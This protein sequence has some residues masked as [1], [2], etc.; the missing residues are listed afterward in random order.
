MP[1]GGIRLESA[2]LRTSPEPGTFYLGQGERLTFDVAEASD[3]AT[4]GFALTGVTRDPTLNPVAERPA[5]PMN[6][7]RRAWAWV[8]CPALL[9]NYF[10][11]GALLLAEP[12]AAH[13][14]FFRLAPSWALYPLVA[15]STVATVIASQALISGVYSLT[16][17]A[18][19]LGLLPRINV[20]HTSDQQSG[21]VYVPVINWLLMLVTIGLVLKAG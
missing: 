4:F 11:Q 5:S 2:G 12:E 8:V 9:L 20:L 7:I 19:M 10:G 16:R 13:S 17:Q 18:S 15:L 6:P 1:V 21:Q 14:P 3:D